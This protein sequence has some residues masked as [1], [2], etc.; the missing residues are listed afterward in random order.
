[1]TGTKPGQVHTRRLCLGSNLRSRIHRA[2]Q[3]LCIYLNMLIVVIKTAT[4][5][6]IHYFN[7]LSLNLIEPVHCGQWQVLSAS[8]GAFYGRIQLPY[9]SVRVDVRKNGLGRRK[10]PRLQASRQILGRSKHE[11]LS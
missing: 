9:Q 1:V 10:L 8:D 5:V 3:S 2:G 4:A 6:F 7:D 11:R